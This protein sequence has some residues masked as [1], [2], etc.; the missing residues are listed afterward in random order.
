[1]TEFEKWV[2]NWIEFVD[3][4]KQ[5]PYAKSTLTSNKIKS[6]KLDKVNDAYEFWLAVASAADNFSDDY[7]VIVIGMD[8]DETIITQVQLLGGSDSFNAYANFQKKDVWALTLF[9]NIYTIVLLQ[10]I[11]KLDDASK[12][13]EKKGH[14]EH[15]HPYRYNKDIILR[16]KLRDNLDE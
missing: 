8:T 11:I 5:C 2:I 9:S 1:M 12:V 3:R 13:L 15:H 6:I 14:Y 4:N 16:R 7:D 10:S